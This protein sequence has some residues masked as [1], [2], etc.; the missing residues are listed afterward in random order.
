[1]KTPPIVKTVSSIGNVIFSIL[2]ALS[3]LGA[4]GLLLATL[5]LSFLPS[6]TVQVDT[7]AQVSMQ[8]NFRQLFGETWD[9]AKDILASGVEGAEITEDGFKVEEITPSQ[10][11]ENRKMALSLIPSFAQMVVLFFF[12]R[13]FP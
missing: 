13:F 2:Q 8:F 3:V 6:G 7:S 10:T 11:L 5:T 12:F 4:V 9:E 1:M